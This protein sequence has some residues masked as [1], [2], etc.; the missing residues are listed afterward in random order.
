MTVIRMRYILTLTILCCVLILNIDFANGRRLI[1]SSEL[2]KRKGTIKTIELIGQS[3]DGEVIDCVDIYKQPAFDHPLLKN[4]IIEVFAFFPSSIQINQLEGENDD[5][6][7]ALQVWRKYGECPKG[8]IPIVRAP[9][10][11]KYGRKT[12]F[13]SHYRYNQS[14]FVAPGHEYAEVTMNGG[15]YFGAKANINVWTP[16]SH[17]TISVAQIWVVSSSQVET[18]IN[19][20]EAGWI[21]DGYRTTGC[22]NLDC[23]GFVQVSKSAALGSILQPV[24]IFNGVQTTIQV[25]LAQVYY[26]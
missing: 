13:K 3:E 25:S 23:P 8:T 22:Y 11:S 20:V 14:H 1:L 10:S 6:L 21:S 18:E 12:H 24:S 17:G 7:K 16:V 9:T 15:T 19:T 5:S 26:I 2:G 4:H